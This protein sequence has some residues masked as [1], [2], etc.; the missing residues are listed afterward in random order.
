MV[1]Y[2]LST[3]PQAEAG[4]YLTQPKDEAGGF[5]EASFGAT[6]EALVTLGRRHSIAAILGVDLGG[7]ASLERR[8][9]EGG[10]FIHERDR[11][12][13]SAARSAAEELG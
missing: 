8:K 12:N 7:D 4:Y 9:T 1:A 5:S 10:P 6:I 3:V 11:L 13:L 2:L